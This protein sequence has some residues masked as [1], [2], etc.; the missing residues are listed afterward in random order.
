MVKKKIETNLYVDVATLNYEK[1]REIIN[2]KI[3]QI[4]QKE[5]NYKKNY[6]TIKV[7]YSNFFR[8]FFFFYF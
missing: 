1:I 7:F 6:L 5:F 2:M 3:D 4:E 8:K